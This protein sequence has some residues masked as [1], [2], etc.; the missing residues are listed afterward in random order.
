MKLGLIADVHADAQ[1]LA[2]VLERLEALGA[3]HVLCAGDLVDYGCCAEET[4]TLIRARGIACVCGN[5]DREAFAREPHKL[6]PHHTDPARLSAANAQFLRELPF[7]FRASYNGLRVAVYHASP[8]YDMALVHPEYWSDRAMAG[9]LEAASADVL[10]LGHTH[11]PIH[12][13]T[14][15]GLV[16]NPGSVLARHNTRLPTSRTFGLLDVSTQAYTLYDVEAGLPYPLTSWRWK[17]T[18]RPP[19]TPGRG[20]SPGG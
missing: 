11:I 10:V 14:P 1:T 9:L 19:L 6:K 7:G 13:E 2:R 3:E 8:T 20:V 5:H 17:A 12:V 15:A 18:K 16:I 4:I